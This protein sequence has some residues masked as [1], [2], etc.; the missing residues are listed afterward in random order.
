VLLR[1]DFD[2]LTL[3]GRFV[4]RACTVLGAT[5]LVPAALGFAWG[6]PDE[7]LGFVIGAS[8]S[9]S[10][11]AVSA[12]RPAPRRTEQWHHGMLVAACIWLV[13]PFLG[14]V[15]LALSGHFGGFGDAFFEAMSGFTTS[16]LSVAHDLD[17]LADSVNVWRH[18]LH[19]LGGQGLIIM[20][21]SL[22]ATG[23]GA[24][25]MYVGE[26]RDERILPNVARTSRFIWRVTLAF[27]VGG[28]FALAVALL[29][30]GTPWELALLHAPLLF[31]AAFDTGGFAPLSSSVGF[32]HSVGVELVTAV[33]MVAGTL[34][35]A[36]HFQLWNRRPLELLRATEVR[37]LASTLL[38]TF[39]VAAVGLVRS[40]AYT[41]PV[42]LFRRGFYQVISAH[43]GTGFQTV[44]GLTLLN[45]WGTLAPA[46]V[47]VAMSLG[48]MAGSTAGG[49]KAIRLVLA[50]K[51][52]LQEIR[53]VIRPPSAVTVETYHAER[54]RVVHDGVVRSALLVLLL[55][56]LLY[57]VGALAGM[58]YGYEF[59]Q[60][61][62]ESVSAGANVG[63]T[64]GLTGPGLEPG[65]KVVYVLQMWIGRLEFIAVFALVGYAISAL[66]GRA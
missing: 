27:G 54:R 28:T 19:L 61:F 3:I 12:L 21:L 65:L 15:P 57:L 62:F 18:V 13:A 24:V 43:T 50:G 11:G 9:L 66:R 26:A 56:L 1:P 40:E 45:G 38:L 25:G 64:T 53:R 10:L 44:P 47:V 58:F 30:A 49:I 59:D 16:G 52:V 36:L 20:L 51:A 8:L 4:G 5:M 33:L 29:V 39:T 17:H 37:M 2:D 46:M 7:A 32:Y 6:E 22:F 14:A 42:E 34:S 55:Y 48:G 41:E 60:A 31:M 23:G 35:F 63:L